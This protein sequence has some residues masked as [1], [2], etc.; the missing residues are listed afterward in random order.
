[1]EFIRWVLCQGICR[2]ICLSPL[3]SILCPSL[4]LL[5]VAGNYISQATLQLATRFS[6]WEIPDGD[7]R[8]RKR[9][10]PE[11]FFPLSSPWVASPASAASLASSPWFQLLLADSSFQVPIIL[12]SFCS[13]SLRDA[14]SFLLL[15]ISGLLTSALPHCALFG[16]FGSSRAYEVSFLD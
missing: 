3:R 13:S 12:L 4:A 9:E 16:L 2:V 5:S 14:K 15:L 11:Y 10:K 6:Q 7:R 8:G 1:M